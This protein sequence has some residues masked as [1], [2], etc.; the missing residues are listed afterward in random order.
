MTTVTDNIIYKYN[1]HHA[2]SLISGLFVV[3]EYIY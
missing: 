2:V 3:S 1:V